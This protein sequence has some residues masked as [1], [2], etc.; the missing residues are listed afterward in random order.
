MAASHRQN[1]KTLRDEMMNALAREY[2]RLKPSDPRRTE[3]AE[4]ISELSLLAAELEK[5]EILQ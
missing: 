2:A 5:P 3:I 4:Q 1:K